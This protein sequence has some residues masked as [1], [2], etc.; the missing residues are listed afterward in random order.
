MWGADQIEA[1]GKDV[2][3]AIILAAMVVATLVAWYMANRLPPG[4]H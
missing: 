2:G 4:R 1:G 3:I